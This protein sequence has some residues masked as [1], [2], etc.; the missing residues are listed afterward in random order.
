MVLSYR[1]KLLNSAFWESSIDYVKAKKFEFDK[2]LD[3]D[4][5]L[6]QIEVMNLRVMFTGC[7]SKAQI[8][9]VNLGIYFTVLQSK[10]FNRYEDVFNL[11]ILATYHWW[12]GSIYNIVS[13]LHIP[14][15]G[16]G[17]KGVG[18]R[19]YNNFENLFDQK[20]SAVLLVDITNISGLVVVGVIPSPF[21]YADVVTTTHKSLCGPRRSMIFFRKG[22]KEINK[23]RQEANDDASVLDTPLNAR[24]S[25]GA[26]NI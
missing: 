2:Y 9:L 10:V 4:K 15:H 16:H 25:S 7:I 11:L 23:Q 5:L 18:E 6:K 1:K 13:S 21:D 26:S 22:V 14:L 12:E 8:L 17:Y 20:G 3:Y 24:G 19:N